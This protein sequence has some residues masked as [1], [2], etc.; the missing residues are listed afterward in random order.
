MVEAWLQGSEAF[1]VDIKLS[2]NRLAVFIDKPQGITIEE[3]TALS[4]HLIEQ[5]EPGGFLEHHEVEVSSPGMDSPLVVPQQYL[6]R[7][8]NELRVLGR[9]GSEW[10][11]IL[12]AVDDS[13][14]QLHETRTRRIDKK[15]VNEELMH[16]ITFDQIKEAKLKFNF[17]F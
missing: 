8:G 14:I 15:K 12:T 10:K 17:K 16:R 3:C 13:G 5:L 9:D 11:G 2:P 4:R 6:R 7:I 1:L